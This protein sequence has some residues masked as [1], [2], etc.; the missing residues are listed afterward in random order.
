MTY[1]EKIKK[2]IGDYKEGA[3]S[4]KDPIGEDADY[5]Q[6]RI[7]ACTDIL[8]LIDSLPEEPASEEPEEAARRWNIIDSDN[9]PKPD[10][11]K[12]YYVCTKGHYLLAT[13]INHPDDDDLLQWRCTEFPFHRYDMC[14][15]DSY[16]P[17]ETVY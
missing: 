4:S 13:V 11:K 8:S 1:K 12:M 15:G 10:K 2:L 16:M 5:F 9:C 14:E 6:G 17:I 3:V 7:D